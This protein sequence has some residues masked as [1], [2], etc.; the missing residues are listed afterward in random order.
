[1]SIYEVICYLVSSFQLNI[2]S[3]SQNG[4][5]L[6]SNESKTLLSQKTMT[7]KEFIQVFK[8]GYFK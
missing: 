5:W 7:R 3:V 1:M 4:K 6:A 2:N 8:S